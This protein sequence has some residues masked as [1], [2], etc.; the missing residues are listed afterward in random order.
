MF[1]DSEKQEMN[2]RGS[3]EKG[4]IEVNPTIA[5]VYHLQTV[6]RTQQRHRKQRE[7]GVSELKKQSL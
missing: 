6:S 2:V 7:V 1:P 4:E 3:S 5:P